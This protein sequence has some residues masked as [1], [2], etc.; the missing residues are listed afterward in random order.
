[1]ALERRA[2]IRST[3][4]KRRVAES[5]R[6]QVIDRSMLDRFGVRADGLCN[7]WCDGDLQVLRARRAAREERQREAATALQSTW[8]GVNHR[9]KRRRAEVRRV[10]RHRA[11]VK[12]Q[13]QW[14]GFDER[15]KVTRTREQQVRGNACLAVAWAF[16]V[17]CSSNREVMLCP[18]HVT[19]RG[20]CW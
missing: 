5:A 17:A 2:R 6:L 18:R 16:G 15:R 7:D 14:R 8:R 11:S 13:S 4:R 3:D 19:K 10:T 20:W 1:V 12:V 9:T